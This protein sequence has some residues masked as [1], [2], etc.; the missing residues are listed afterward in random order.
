[1]NIYSIRIKSLK[2]FDFPFPAQ[3]DG[4]AM[5]IVSASMKGVEPERL[6]KIDIEN[7]SLFRLSAFDSKEG[8][9]AV[10]PR[11]VSDLKDIPGLFDFFK[12]V[13]VPEE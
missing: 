6:K 3:D 11:L 12:S 8:I 7:L 9:K 5:S 4:K 13:V 2:V 10:K 1:M